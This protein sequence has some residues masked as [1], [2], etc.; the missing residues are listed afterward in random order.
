VKDRSLGSFVADIVS[1]S[2][3]HFP[4]DN[5]AVKILPPAYAFGP[6]GH[7]FIEVDFIE[8]GAC[9]MLFGTEYVKLAANDC[10][11][12]FPGVSHYF[13]TRA[14]GGCTLVQVEFAAENLPEAAIHAA[15]LSFVDELNA[16]R[17]SFLKF[18]PRSWVVECIR[19]IREESAGGAVGKEEMLKLLFA[20]FFILLSREISAHFGENPHEAE[21]ADIASRARELLVRLQNEGSGPVRIE[22]MAASLGV[23][24][25]Y[26]RRT[27]VSSFGT[28]IVE[29]L[30]GLRL[31]KARQLLGEGKL[32]VL[33]V[34]LEC[35][36]SS[37]QYFDRV[38]RKAMGMTPLA[39]RTLLESARTDPG[40]C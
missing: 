31:R 4:I 29:Y 15:S 1:N 38:F 5:V 30:T 22:D 37:S 19:A 36:F 10:I 18:Q 9:G 6:H 32:S 33:E 28:G 25:R 3:I 16:G 34:A 40:S 27:F 11:L 12:I 2:E 26:L 14:R 39:F 20:R 23:S 7:R 21:G 24:S 13:F 17:H 8:E 35:G